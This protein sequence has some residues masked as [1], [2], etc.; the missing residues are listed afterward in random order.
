MLTEKNVNKRQRFGLRKLTVGV[1]SV[2]LGTTFFMG[3][4]VAQADTSASSSTEEQPV[5]QQVTSTGKNETATTGNAVQLT[6]QTTATP[7]EGRSTTS[8]STTPVSDHNSATQAINVKAATESVASQAN[9]KQV[10]AE[11]AQ[12]ADAEITDNGQTEVTLTHGQQQDRRTLAFSIVAKAGDNVTVTT[13]EIFDA[14]ADSDPSM[15]VSVVENKVDSGQSFTYSFTAKS[16][17]SY[18]LNIILKPLVN[19]WAL[20]PAGNKYAVNVEKNGN[21]IAQLV[22][23][24]D[25]PAVITDS[26]V[27]VDPNQHGNLVQGQKYAIAVN[28]PNT[29]AN[30]GDNFKGT[31]TVQVPEGFQ[32]ESNRG[33]GFVSATNYG[34]TDQTLPDRFT[35]ISQPGDT[36]TPVV[37]GIDNGKSLLNSDLILFWGTY[38]KTLTAEQNN[39]KVDVSYQ[40]ENNGKVETLVHT[41][42][43]TT[44]AINLPVTDEQR[45]S[46]TPIMNLPEKVDTD[47]GTANGQHQSDETDK[48]KYPGGWS[49]NLRNDGNVE[50]TNVKLHLDV[51]PGTIFKGPINLTTTNENSGFTVTTT[52]VDGSK[53]NLN[54]AVVSGSDNNSYNAIINDPT[55]KDGSNIKAIDISFDQIQAGSGVDITLNSKG[56]ILS[57]ATTK[58]VGD[59]AEYGYK[60][61]S[62]QGIVKSDAKDIKIAA[63]DPIEQD[64][65]F[66]GYSYG[67]TNGN[68]DKNA[69][70]TAALK[71]GQIG[72]KIAHSKEDLT[73]PSSYLLVIPAGFHV[74]SES[75]MGVM[76]KGKYL[77]APQAKITALGAIGPAGE[78]V[79]RLDLS[80]TPGDDGNGT[81][82]YVQKADN[83]PFTLGINSNQGP[84]TYQY[85]HDFGYPQGIALTMEIAK[86]GTLVPHDNNQGADFRTITLGGKTYEVMPESNGWHWDQ[87][88]SDA[89]Y[90]FLGQS[91][92]GSDSG[93][94]NNHEASYHDAFV[95]GST[96]FTYSANQNGVP[97]ATYS[98]GQIRLTNM[99]TDGGTSNYSYNVINL[100]AASNGDPI[101]LN[102]TG[103]GTMIGDNTGSSELLYSLT[104][105]TKGNSLTEADLT[106]FVTADQITDWSK[107]RAVLL[108]SNKLTNGAVI[109][110]YIPFT[111]SGMQ[112]GKESVDYDLQNL[113]TGDHKGSTF[114]NNGVMPL[115][116]DRYVQ[117]TTNW[118]K[119]DANGKP[120]PIKSSVN[121]N[122]ESGK[123][124][125]TDPLSTAEIP[126]NYH[127]QE[128]PTNA[129]GT[130][131]AQNIIVNYIYVQ[132]AVQQAQL[133]FVDDD[134]PSSTKM[135]ASISAQGDAGSE[136]NFKNQ[137]GKS[138]AEIVEG[139]KAD[140]Y[141][142]AKGGVVTNPSSTDWLTIFGTYDSDDQTTQSFTIHFTH[143]TQP[144]TE[145]ATAS[146]KIKY[147]YS[148]GKQTGL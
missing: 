13:P 4:Q 57:A 22:Y 144:V 119:Q 72:Y 41:F 85:G 76:Y 126:Q 65:S 117:V 21:K 92:Y 64:L 2:L 115:H 60:V 140:H 58:K 10:Q 48:Y 69:T 83:V 5:S 80:F 136:I 103:K 43:G 3:T 110:A 28:L 45:S 34:N 102:L 38:T 141:V 113:F 47:N 91:R 56:A 142:L 24:I 90:T 40:T 98:N 148:D 146:E 66:A 129:T 17:N 135:P 107:V 100:P 35:S 31:V 121:V 106:N 125:S 25:Q 130:T 79:Y 124:Y 18:S 147:V 55:A 46:I 52:L 78:Y 63:P 68:Y 94:K 109:N 139:L 71:S 112:D 132:N 20:L 81:P 86:K 116:V 134:D 15:G 114:D 145:N 118:Y 133:N 9:A 93:I 138:V 44:Q 143:A 97:D 122:V 51:E 54:T 7:T 14:S 131:G 62:D 37:I 77:S 95:T 99:L 82:V 11:L 89:T 88:F 26:K 29:G 105:V 74:I 32:L 8:Q 61:T 27:S 108:K 30:D 137:E 120:T 36:G 59:Q 84:A 33:Y 19:D 73:R 75:D 49:F 50:Q 67:F 12:T 39:F 128:I 96:N 1:A 16:N 53:L 70:G 42:N 123:N 23:T 87:G 6:K 104:P 101:T 111:V 127:L